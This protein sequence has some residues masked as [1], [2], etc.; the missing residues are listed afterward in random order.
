[1]S[2][3]ATKKSMIKYIPND[4][5]IDIAYYFKSYV[6]KIIIIFFIGAFN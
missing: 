5:I 6:K 3:F 4:Y 2:K 1:M